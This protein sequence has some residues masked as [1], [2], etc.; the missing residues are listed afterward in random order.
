M[1]HDCVFSSSNIIVWSST[2]TSMTMC[3][4]LSSNLQAN[5]DWNDYDDVWSCCQLSL[6]FARCCCSTMQV[7]L[8]AIIDVPAEN[9]QLSFNEIVLSDQN[10]LESYDI[11]GQSTV[12][13]NTEL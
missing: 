9:L 5:C 12:Q 13:I 7:K 11:T 8:E 6:G 1:Q 10:T 4:L 3:W 2:V